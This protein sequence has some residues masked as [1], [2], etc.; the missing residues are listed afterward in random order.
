MPER[1]FRAEAA[2]PAARREVRGMARVRGAQRAARATRLRA[3]RRAARALVRAAWLRAAARER[4]APVQ[5]GRE[6]AGAPAAR[7]AERVEAPVAA[8]ERE[9]P[10]VAAV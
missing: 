1:D 6:K 3:A 4:L 5:A 2:A 8:L 7:K 10:R 9:A